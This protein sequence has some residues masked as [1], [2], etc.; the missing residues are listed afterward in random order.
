MAAR[1][2]RAPPLRL[3]LHGLQS[4]INVGTLLR[5][6]ETFGVGVD[7]WDPAGLFRDAEKLRWIHD[8]SCGAYSRGAFRLLDDAPRPREESIRTIAT[9]LREEAT[10][11]PDFV[12]RPGDLVAIGNEYD[13]LPADY[14][15]GADC[16]LHI[17]MPAGHTPKLPSLQPIDPAHQ[18]VDPDD[19]SPVLSSAVSGAIICYAASLPRNS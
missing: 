18:P 12:F 7:V 1:S 4:P 17:P 15:A 11:L 16:R 8:L 10:R 3:L 5:V 19:G 13:G 14:I 6:A 9:C 2:S